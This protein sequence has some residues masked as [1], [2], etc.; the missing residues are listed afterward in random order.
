MRPLSE[1]VAF[2]SVCPQGSSE[3][4]AAAEP[5]A[6][7]A[8]SGCLAPGAPGSPLQQQQQRQQRAPVAALPAAARLPRA[9]GLR[10]AGA[11]GAHEHAGLPRRHHAVL[12]LLQL[13]SPQA[14]HRCAEPGS[15]IGAGHTHL[16]PQLVQPAIAS[17][18]YAQALRP[19]ARASLRG[20]GGHVGTVL[21]IAA[22]SAAACLQ[23]LG[24]LPGSRRVPAAA[25]ASATAA[26]LL[27]LRLAR[28]LR[29]WSDARS[30]PQCP[31]ALAAAT[32]RCQCPGAAQGRHP[33]VSDTCMPPTPRDFICTHSP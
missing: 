4:S 27:A 2:L 22:T 9:R 6:L 3:A 8:G 5:S 30:L 17:V 32:S 13:C 28:P 24:C 29:P 21:A 1:N 11:R 33:R 20:T 18:P 12:R 7:G 19:R 23:P 25:T 26:Q 14:V 10:V 15:G 16:Q 31:A